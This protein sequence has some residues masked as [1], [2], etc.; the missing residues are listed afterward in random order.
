M[1]NLFDRLPIL[2]DKYNLFKSYYRQQGW[3]TNTWYFSQYL[4]NCIIALLQKFPGQN[5]LFRLA[6][7]KRNRQFQSLIVLHSR[8]LCNTL[9]II[10]LLRYHQVVHFNQSH[11]SSWFQFRTSQ[12][13]IR[14]RRKTIS[15]THHQRI[16]SHIKQIVIADQGASCLLYLIH[17]FNSNFENTHLQIEK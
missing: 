15:M 10:L 7:L 2:L 6:Q 9:H 13:V 4:H 12:L 1:T 14:Y 8:K 17:R 11:P 3:I 16:V 5:N